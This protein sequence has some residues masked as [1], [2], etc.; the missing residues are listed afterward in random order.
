MAEIVCPFCGIA[1]SERLVIEA[2]I[3]EEHYE[4]HDSPSNDDVRQGQGARFDDLAQTTNISDTAKEPQ[5]TKC[6]RPGCGE[7]VLLAD[8]DEHLAVHA[9]LNGAARRDDDDPANVSSSRS[10]EA[11]QRQVKLSKSNKSSSRKSSTPTLLEYFSGTSYHG[12]RPVPPPQSKKK[13]LPPGRLGRRELGPHAF[14]KQMPET[15]RRRLER[16]ALPQQV[17]HISKS[18]KLTTETF[19]PNETPGLISVLAS[20]CAKDHE[21]D[22]TFFCNERT[23]HV[24][25]LRCDGNF[26]GYWN[27]QML[28]SYLRTS[29]ALPK[30][31]NMPN[32]LQIQDTIETAWDNNILAYGRTETGG[33]KGTRKWIGTAEAAAYF[34]QVGISVEAHSFKDEGNELAVV[35]LLDFVESYFISGVNTARHCDQI[36]P[37]PPPSTSVITSLPPIYFQ[38]FG[39]S[40]T[41]IGLEHRRDGS[42]NLLVFDPSFETAAEMRALVAGRRRTRGE[43]AAGLLRPYRK[44]DT[45]LM[46]WE[47]FEILTVT[48]GGENG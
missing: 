12:K 32:V 41:I 17:Q 42:R 26:C 38:R 37:P 18:G 10:S 48:T 29:D 31:R 22:A 14:E 30:E 39:H 1:S 46:R 3:E 36:P 16:D 35:N 19:V 44:C 34:R 23:V 21:N 28:L 40:M 25:K 47:E 24:N 20:L 2:H 7:Y 43:T 9:S 5:W 27:I 15:V 33:V 6:T 8:V 11:S 13:S 45:L 4:R